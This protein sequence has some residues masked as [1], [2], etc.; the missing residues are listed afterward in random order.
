MP[1]VFLSYTLTCARIA[2]ATKCGRSSGIRGSAASSASI[3]Q[4]NARRSGSIRPEC[5]NP[6]P[7]R[8]DSGDCKGKV[9]LENCIVNRSPGGAHE[10]KPGDKFGPYEL[11]SSI[12][13]GGMGEVWKARDTRLHGYQVLLEPVL[14]SLH[15]RGPC[16]RCPESLQY[17]HAARYRAGLSGHGESPCIER[18]HGFIV[19]LQSIASCTQARHPERFPIQRFSEIGAAKRKHDR[20]VLRSTNIGSDLSN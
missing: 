6:L 3:D 18:S 4:R 7:C 19:D 12:G 5:R 10:R 2:R 15:A 17:M 14:R 16:H 8:P 11:V 9:S 13:K 20:F 1:P